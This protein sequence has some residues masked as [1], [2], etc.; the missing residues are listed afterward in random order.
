MQIETLK[1]F[2][3]LAEAGSFYGA[4]RRAFISQQ[5]LNKAITALEAE[6][7]VHLVERG[8]RGVRLTTEGDIF[9]DYA[10]RALDAHGTML[11]EIYAENRYASPDGSPLVFHV[12]YYPA[13]ISR[14]FVYGMGAVDSIRIVEESFRRVLEGAAASDGSEL[15][16]ADLYAGTRQDAETFEGLV[17]EPVLASQFGIVWRDGSPLAGRRVI[18]REQ[19]ADFP[20]AVVSHREMMK[21]V[22]N[23]MQDYPLNNIRQGMAEPR[24]TLEYARSSNQVASTFDSFGFE[25]ARASSAIQTDG[26][27]FTPFSTPRS[28]CLIGFLYAKGARPSMRARRAIDRLKHYLA[29]NYADYLSRYPLERALA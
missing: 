17:F 26:L 8:S 29:E 23:V 13:Q 10:R 1:Y 20:L 25:L 12:T 18:H 28:L 9:L 14:P 7:G 2:V 22:E 3:E 5:G 15:Y 24:T 27:N 4:A 11:D 6:L 21:L 19:L 16:L